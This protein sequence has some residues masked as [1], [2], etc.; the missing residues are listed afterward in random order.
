MLGAITGGLALWHQHRTT[1]VR[2]RITPK[3]VKH[4]DLANVVTSTTD[5]ELGE[6]FCIEVANLSAFAV[7][8]D[9]VG[10]LTPSNRNGDRAVLMPL[11][12]DGGGWPRRL[13]PHTSV[14]CYST[15]VP[16]AVL[17]MTTRCY[18]QTASGVIRYG[19]S[20]ALCAMIRAA[21]GLS[22]A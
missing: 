21:R 4:R 2:L 17:R 7:T 13:E 22:D 1:R 11:T 16:A 20:P 6:E 8:I 9:E 12:F 15:P 10:F 18:A 5:G 14:N 3:A 19:S